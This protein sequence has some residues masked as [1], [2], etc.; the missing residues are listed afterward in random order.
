MCLIRR[1]FKLRVLRSQCHQINFDAKKCSRTS[2]RSDREYTMFAPAQLLRI[3]REQR[4]SN[5]GD[6]DSSVTEEVWRV[7][8]TRVD[9]LPISF[10]YRSA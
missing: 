6:L 9:L 7:C 4:L 8:C 10:L 5:N 1:V 2:T 3:W